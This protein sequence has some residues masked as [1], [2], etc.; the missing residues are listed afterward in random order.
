MTDVRLASLTVENRQAVEAFAES[1]RAAQQTSQA[2]EAT[3]AKLAETTQAWKRVEASI[4]GS[5]AAM[6]RFEAVAK[7]AKVAMDQGRIGAESYAL[8]IDRLGKRYLGTAAT[9]EQA[10]ALEARGHKVAA[11]AVRGLATAYAGLPAGANAASGG[12]R[13]LGNIAQQAG[14]QISDV[15][16]VAAAGG[17]A[18]AAAGTQ[19][20][21]FLGAFGPMGAVVGAAAT[22]G[23]L[24]AAN[25]LG[26]GDATKLAESAAETYKDALKEL[27]DI[28]ADY[29]KALRER[30]GLPLLPGGTSAIDRRVAEARGRLNALGGDDLQG[31]KERSF[32]GGLYDSTKERLGFGRTASPYEAAKAEYDAALA[33]QAVASATQEAAAAERV[34]KALQD[35]GKARS[36]EA[37]IAQLSEK[38]REKAV[39]ALS[40]E[41]EVRDRLKDAPKSDVDAEVKVARAHAVAMVELAQ[42][43]KGAEKAAE[44]HKKALEDLAKSAEQSAKQYGDS[45]ASADAYV[46]SLK[47]EAAALGMTE[48]EAEIYRAGIKA[49]I[50]LRKAN[51]GHLTDEAAARVEAAKA[52]AANLYDAKEGKKANEERERDYLKSIEAA[53]KERQR[54]VEH[55]SEEIGDNLVDVMMDVG[56]KSGKEIATSIGNWLKRSA[57]QIAVNAAV[58]PYLMQGV[59]Y[60]M[61]AV[62]GP[63]GVAAGAAGG[64]AGAAAGGAGGSS[65]LMGAGSLGY[66]LGSA[67]SG[68]TAGLMASANTWGAANLGTGIDAA[69]A[70]SLVKSGQGFTF[71]ENGTTF[72][73]TGG[74]VF[75]VGG[76][77]VGGMTLTDWAGAAGAAFNNYTALTSGT[78]AQKV[79]TPAFTGIGAALGS[80]TPLGPWGGAA[81]GSTIG[82][83]IGGLFG[84]GKDVSY[85]GVTGSVASAESAIG[86]GNQVAPGAVMGQTWYGDQRYGMGPQYGWGWATS[87]APKSL[88]DAVGA[89]DGKALELV[90]NLGYRYGA[91]L[92]GQNIG[93]RSSNGSLSLFTRRTDNFADAYTNGS[94]IKGA[95]EFKY[96]PKT[97][98]SVED[99][100][101][102]L[103]V[104]M[105]A[106]AASVANDNLSKAAKKIDTTLDAK[107]I[108]DLLT[109]AE[110]FDDAIT[111][112]MGGATDVAK[113]VGVQTRNEVMQTISAITD[114]RAKTAQLGLDTTKA[115]DATKSA[116]EVMLG[117]KEAAKPLS[118]VDNA[119]QSLEAKF[120]NIGPLL[121]FV[122]I[123]ETPASLREKALAN[124]TAGF[125]AATADALA[126]MTDP[127]SL[128]RKAENDRY[129]QQLADAKKLNA[130]LQTVEQIHQL[131]MLEIDKQANQAAEQA[132]ESAANSVMGTVSDLG[133]LVQQWQYGDASA[134]SPESQLGMS[135]R[136]Y[137]AVS[138]A[139]LAGDYRS[140]T[141]YGATADQY[142]TEARAIYG[143]GAGYADAFARVMQDA[144]KLMERDPQDLVVRAVEYGAQSQVTA[145]TNMQAELVRELKALREEMRQSN[146]IPA[147]V[148]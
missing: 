82:N 110:N 109:F 64:A 3:T 11:E 86:A 89:M 56:E 106:R 111:T 47:N 35:L 108:N 63:A 7:Q 81:L 49:E 2:V 38:E 95:A 102:R 76:S 117:L 60:A 15:A 79:M 116:V 135:E 84:R 4:P 124:M 138:G 112:M 32:F 31:K 130:D 77:G 62:A 148:A 118:D 140:F 54:I 74:N 101:A 41:K 70:S 22:V 10:A 121:D 97:D 83:L 8:E 105:L 26:A 68:G 43:Q 78:A 29:N 103:S 107:S 92:A 18:L 104:V 142:L 115:A 80:L 50:D 120:T 69:T 113:S 131:K 36:D 85:Y 136:T 40:A 42:S 51:N 98:G 123:T 21:Q 9:I 72:L 94:D 134:L 33:D 16:A 96:D 27:V 137:N 23:G 6:A 19:L 20:G 88:T 75:E 1:T 13:N 127:S 144:A 122:G 57:F 5:A 93:V 139:A 145:I 37:S 61:N 126:S 39:A 66:Q 99:A 114:F 71:T 46:D 34:A 55:A 25:M 87:T 90:A 73:E 132:R 45:I 58:T 30:Q 12:F 53:E 65:N 129:E 67:G 91:N 125:N 48:R 100:V 128:L 52:A 141:Q 133:K 143:S 146:N 28:E 59:G 119:L 147:R 44:D 17:N 24:F 14:Y